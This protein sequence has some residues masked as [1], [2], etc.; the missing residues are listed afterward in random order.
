M[1]A[2]NPL[3]LLP[4][5]QRASQQRLGFAI[6]TLRDIELSQLVQAESREAILR[7]ACVRTSFLCLLVV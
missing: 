1:L 4:D 3:L 5:R 6:A 2:L 7:V